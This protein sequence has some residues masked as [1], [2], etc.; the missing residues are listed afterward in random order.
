MTGLGPFF[1]PLRQHVS[2]RPPNKKNDHAKNGEGPDSAIKNTEGSLSGDFSDPSESQ[3]GGEETTPLEF[4]V[5][6][7]LR[8]AN[9]ICVAD[10]NLSLFWMA[11][12]VTAPSPNPGIAHRADCQVSLDGLTPISA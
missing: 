10:H 12:I 1:S 7:V 2:E 9:L 4:V 11:R 5:V 3:R 8:G 6:M